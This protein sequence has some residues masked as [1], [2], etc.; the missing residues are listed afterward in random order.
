[1]LKT[2][3]HYHFFNVVLFNNNFVILQ[4]VLY[5]TIFVTLFLSKNYSLKHLRFNLEKPC[6]LFSKS[7]SWREKEDGMSSNQR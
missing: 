5:N 6:S 4:K 3:Q 2:S 1:M 7:I